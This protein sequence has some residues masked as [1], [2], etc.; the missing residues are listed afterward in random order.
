MST[1]VVIGGGISGLSCALN[2]ADARPD[3]TIRVLEASERLGGTIYTD[4]TDGWVCEAGPG[5]FIDRDPSTR[6][7]IERLNLSDELITAG[8]A[9]RGRYIRHQGSLHSFPDSPSALEKTKLLSEK[10]RTR[11]RLSPVLPAFPEDQ[12]V[13][14]FAAAHLGTEAASVLLDPIVAGIYAGDPT[15]LSARSVLPR[16]VNFAESGRRVCDALIGQGQG[17]LGKG[18]MISISGGMGRLVEALETELGDRVE[19]SRPVLGITRGL[20]NWRVEVGGSEPEVIEADAVVSALHGPTATTL[21]GSLHPEL[22]H[23]LKKIPSA[24]VAVVHLGFHKKDVGRT[25]D[26]FGYLIPSSEGGAVLGVKWTTSI[27]PNGRAPEG[28]VLMQVY[29]GGTRDPELA[30]DEAG[31]VLAARNEIA[32][33]LNV[34]VE[35]EHVRVFTH[36]VGIPQYLRGH[37]QRISAIESALSK[38]PG[39]YLAGTS[40]HGVGIN[41]CTTRA[42][43]IA[44]QI[45]SDL[46]VKPSANAQTRLSLA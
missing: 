31:S 16:L 29:V 36:R 4:R 33:I 37:N 45:V 35:P 41:A 10:G 21:M 11:I 5:D 22:E 24:P 28:H 27:F 18:S 7:L 20:G 39:I 30:L 15:E 6:R 12:T 25:L 43:K 40:L 42:E 9:T 19:R 8:N 46:P 34:T 44:E 32:E 2:L 14:E 3:L 1:V 38:V 23:N 26:G 13:N 17:K